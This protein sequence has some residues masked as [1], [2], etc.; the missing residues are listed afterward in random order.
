MNTAPLPVIEAT[1][2]DSE[3]L[4]DVIWFIKGR[5][6][7]LDDLGRRCELDNRHLEA[8]RRFRVSLPHMQEL[9]HR[10]EAAE[11]RAN[12]AEHYMSQPKKK[13]KS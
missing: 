8:L 13:A 4:A 6:S 1:E 9:R 10:A 5:M 2:D 11:K 3:A 12:L 7:A